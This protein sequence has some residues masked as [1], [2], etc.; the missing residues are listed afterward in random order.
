MATDE[1]LWALWEE[2]H[3]NP[4]GLP[5]GHPDKKAKRIYKAPPP[6][7]KKLHLSLVGAGLP[8]IRWVGSPNYTAGRSGHNPDWTNAD[9]NTWITLHTMVGWMQGTINAFLSA[10]RQASSTYGVGLDGTIV[11]FVKESDAPWTNGTMQGVG[12]N[13]DSITI[14]CEDGGNFNGPRTPEMYEA[15]AQLVADIHR[16]HAIPL[17]HR[18]ASGGVLG[19]RECDGA[20][21]ACPDSLGVDATVARANDI[22]NG[23]PLPTPTPPAPTPTP[24]VTVVTPYKAIPGVVFDTPT[25]DRSYLIYATNQFDMGNIA[26]I[27]APVSWIEAKWTPDHGWLLKLDDGVHALEDECVDDSAQ[28]T[29]DGHA[30]A[31]SPPDF[32]TDPHPAPPPD[33]RPEW[34]RN[35]HDAP[36]VFDLYHGI[37]LVDMATGVNTGKT[38]GPGALITASAT[39]AAGVAYAVT[40]YAKDHGTGQG[41]RSTDIQEAIAPGPPPPTPTPE[42]VPVP[43]PVPVPDPGPPVPPAG[44]WDFLTKF[45]NWLLGRKVA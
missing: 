15:L 45:L 27:G 12:S 31:Y 11:Q 44:F 37:P 35:L 16:R 23:V 14:E 4:S 28:A 40:Q 22:V 5:D 26:E 42:P 43:V 13:L 2:R 33:T 20:S 9:P 34:L 21:T 10:A 17:I 18:R 1:E 3:P 38:V 7:H 8:G 30:S 25:N 36:A 6:H 39:T 29:I 24:V 19:H 32:V 41:M